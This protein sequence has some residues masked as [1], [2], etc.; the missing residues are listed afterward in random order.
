MGEIFAWF[1]VFALGIFIGINGSNVRITPDEWHKAEERC[2]TN[3]GVDE[4]VA[5]TLYDNVALCNNTARFV[6]RGEVK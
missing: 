5:K 4:F 6:L 1:G 2:S 3:E